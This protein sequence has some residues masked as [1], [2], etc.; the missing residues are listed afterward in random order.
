[1]HLLNYELIKSSAINLIK[2]LENY[3]YNMDLEE[4]IQKNVEK[5]NKKREKLGIEYG[6]KMAEVA[7]TQTKSINTTALQQQRKN[8]TSYTQVTSTKSDEKQQKTTKTK[9][10]TKS[11]SSY[12][13][14]LKKD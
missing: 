3:N 10:G 5:Q 11:V 9:T 4:M 14:M 1:M 13:H 7:K 8:P 2:Y 6:S 12:A